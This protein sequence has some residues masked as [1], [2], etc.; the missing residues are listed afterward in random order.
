[1]PVVILRKH[2]VPEYRFY[3]MSK[4]GHIVGSPTD[5]ELPNG[6]SALKEAKQFTDGHAVEIWQGARIVAHLDPEG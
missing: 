5:Y 4:D 6:A 1:V 3:K 2:I